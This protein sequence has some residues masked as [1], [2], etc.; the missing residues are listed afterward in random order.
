MMKTGAIKASRQPIV[1]ENRTGS[2]P[3]S[4]LA[5]CTSSASNPHD[6]SVATKSEKAIANANAPKSSGLSTRAATTVYA[7]VAA[8]PATSAA[9]IAERFLAV[10]RV[11][12]PGSGGSIT[13]GT[14]LGGASDRERDVA[15]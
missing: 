15:S 11:F 12:G 3:G 1:S 6:G 8:L 7:S 4:A 2:R 14:T 9:A 5:R 13:A 10:R